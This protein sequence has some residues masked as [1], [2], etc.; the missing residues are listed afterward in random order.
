MFESYFDRINE[1]YNDIKNGRY[2]KGI[3]EDSKVRIV[4]YSCGT[5][6]RIDVKEKV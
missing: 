2:N 4:V 3:I 5:V 1:L 6:I